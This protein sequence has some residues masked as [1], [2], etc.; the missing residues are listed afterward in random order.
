MSAWFTPEIVRLLGQGLVLTVGLTFLTSLL[1]TGLGILIGSLRLLPQRWVTLP[2]TIF[3]ETFRN[4]PAL[5]QIIF[6]AFA[7]PNAFPVEMRA[8]LFFNNPFMNGLTELTGLPVPWYVIAALLGLTLNTAGYIAEIFRAGVATIAREQLDTAKT[9]GAPTL[10]ILRVIIIPIGVRAAYPALTSRLIHNL[11][12]TALASFVSV[13]EFFN[14]VQTSITRS[15]LAIEFLTLAAVVYLLLAL[16]MSLLL[17]GFERLLFP[18][19]TKNEMTT[20]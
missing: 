12:N 10:S 19:S 16:A 1:A 7:F 5:I 14:G 15:F 6:W 8:A 13:P 17:R 9:M 4:I 20:P 11:K 18:F 2:A 3:V